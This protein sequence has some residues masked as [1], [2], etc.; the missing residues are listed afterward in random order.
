MWRAGLA[1][2]APCSLL[3]SQPGFGGPVT[4]WGVP[5]PSWSL[6]CELQ[7][8]PQ[9]QLLEGRDVPRAVLWMGNNYTAEFGGEEHCSSSPAI[10]D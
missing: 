10:S 8:Q 5:V 1:P 3:S 9:A 2:R 7:E 6:L 4:E